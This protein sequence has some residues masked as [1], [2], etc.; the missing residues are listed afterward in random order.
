M[1]GPFS[2]HHSWVAIILHRD[3]SFSRHI[4]MVA[5]DRRGLEYR[6]PSDTGNQCPG[7]ALGSRRDPSSR[8]AGAPNYPVALSREPLLSRNLEG[9]RNSC[10]S[11]QPI[12]SSACGCN[13]GRRGGPAYLGC[14]NL[15]S[16]RCRQRMCVSFGTQ[17]RLG[18]A[19]S[20]SEY[21]SDAGTRT[22]LAR[23][24]LLDQDP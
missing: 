11:F 15:V 4:Y 18:L 19:C 9:R 21:W 1:A 10:Q 16:T 3:P 24:H 12:N 22:R 6:R 23:N 14:R 13:H 7:R 5:V 17:A 8:Q 20:I 2:C